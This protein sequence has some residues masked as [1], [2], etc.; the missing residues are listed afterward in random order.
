M[1]LTIDK[2]EAS[3]RW[4]TEKYGPNAPLVR[5]LTEQLK[6]R[7]QAIADECELDELSEGLRSDVDSQ[8]VDLGSDSELANSFEQVILEPEF[9][10]IDSISQSLKVE[11]L[12]AEEMPSLQIGERVGRKLRD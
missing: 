3:L 6:V 5:S 10:Q 7:S 1:S 2:L 12:D 9:A 11:D 8:R 4:A